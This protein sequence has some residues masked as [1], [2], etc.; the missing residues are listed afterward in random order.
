MDK[1]VRERLLGGASESEIRGISRRKGYQGLLESG[2][3]K[4]QAGL[5][6]AEEVIGA[7]FTESD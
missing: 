5:T 1:E 7:T 3:S 4:I 2:V 6:T